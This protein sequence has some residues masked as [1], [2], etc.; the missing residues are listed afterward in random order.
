[1]YFI[2]M[3]AKQK[4]LETHKGTYLLCI[5]TDVWI[6]KHTSYITAKNV[7]GHIG[8][9]PEITRVARDIEKHSGPN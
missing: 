6:L 9:Y 4:H 3:V 5:L 8:Y 7:G 1:M 2:V